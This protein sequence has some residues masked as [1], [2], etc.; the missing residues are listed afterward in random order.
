MYTRFSDLA[1]L[2]FALLAR[3]SSLLAAGISNMHEVA[4]EAAWAWIFIHVSSQN[5]HRPTD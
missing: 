1:I 3:A 4:G 2:N 5:H